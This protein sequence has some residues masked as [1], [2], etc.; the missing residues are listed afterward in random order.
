MMMK[1][2]VVGGVLA[3]FLVV[4]PAAHAWHIAGKVLCD[5]DHDGH[6]DSDDTPESGVTVEVASKNHAGTMFTDTTDGSGEYSVSLPTTTDDY[7]VTISGSGGATIIFPLSG[8]FMFH[9]DSSE[10]IIDD[11]EFLLDDCGTTTTTHTTTTSTTTTTKPTTTTH[12][13]TTTTTTTTTLP[14]CP[15]PDVPFL[16]RIGGVVNNGATILDDICANDVGGTLRL[17]HNTFMPDGTAVCGD[18]I[19][20]GMGSNV[21]QVLANA[22]KKGADVTVRNGTGTPSLPIIDPFCSLPPIAC[23]GPSV[24]VDAGAT[25]GPLAPGTY[26]DLLVSSGATLILAPGT[27]SFCHVNTARN[28]I[29]TP[30]GPTT[31]NVADDVVFGSSSMVGPPPFTL[32]VAG[33]RV[34]VSQ[35]AEIHAFITAPSAQISFGRGSHL[36]GSF[37]ANSIKTDKGIT[38]ECPC[39]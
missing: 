5:E 9:I 35:K 29:I 16:T 33:G 10:N 7:L 4:T 38:L 3:A 6:I 21:S 34:R 28:A 14:K 1:V 19:A 18:S 36:F 15:C 20:L 17:S 31:I 27:F 25:S 39:P 12:T 23:G 8:S 22:I 13:T 24:R 26:S 2:F 30:T 37:C 32:N 11:V